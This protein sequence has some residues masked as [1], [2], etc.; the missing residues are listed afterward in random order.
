MNQD[1]SSPIPPLTKIEANKLGLRVARQIVEAAHDLDAT[2]EDT[3]IAISA[4]REPTP[5]WPPIDLLSEATDGPWPAPVRLHCQWPSGSVDLLLHVS[6][7]RTSADAYRHLVGLAVAVVLPKRRD[8]VWI[9]IPRVLLAPRNAVRTVRA[10]VTPPRKKGEAD[11][12]DLAAQRVRSVVKRAGL[13]FDTGANV[14]AF[15]VQLSDGT[16]LPS[17]K[18][19][20]QRICTLA[21]GKLPFF[22]TDGKGITGAPPFQPADVVVDDDD[23]APEDLT[24]SG[25]RA[26]IWPL[27]GGV[28]K[29]KVTLDTL[30]AELEAGSVPVETMYEILR[31][32]FDV[33]GETSREQYVNVIEAIGL[34]EKSDGQIGLTK[35]GRDYLVA[36]NASDV[37]DR[38]HAAFIGVLEP[39]VLADEVPPLG[40]K[41]MQQRMRALLGVEW[42]SPNQFNFRRNWLYSLGLTERRDDGDNLTQL[43]RDTVMRYTAEADLVRDRIG[44]VL[45]Q[46]GPDAG[47]DIGETKATS[48]NVPEVSPGLDAPTLASS[49]E[50]PAWNEEVVDL[51]AEHVAPFA[52][53]LVLPP[54]TIER[55]VAALSAGKHLL[56]V[57][58][59]G[60]AKTELAHFIAQAAKR[61]GY[62]AG[63]HVATASADWT[64][65]DT[66][67]G[68]ALQRDG[69]LRFREGAL[70]RAVKQWQWLIVD[71]LNRADV[72][73]AFGELMTVLA[74]RATDTS[75]ELDDGKIVK[76]GLAPDATH[77]TP[78]TFR[79]I[80]TMNT[81]D[82]T[83]LFRLSHA[84]QRR[85][86]IV[87]V[88][89]PADDAYGALVR[90]H[91]SL[92]GVA[93]APLPLA[94]ASSLATLFSRSGLLAARHI[95]PAVALDVIKY[96]RRR[97]TDTGVSAID[98]LAEA[99]AMYVLPQLEGIDQDRA[100]TCFAAIEILAT[101]CSPAARKELRE[102]FAD[103]FPHVKLP[104]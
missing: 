92:P 63:A 7:W 30:L 47:S 90:K 27:P 84:V 23:V 45:D 34:I 36:K 100:V 89:I 68:Y 25:K 93:D 22:V 46:V 17:A 1:G 99:I 40:G 82:K 78:R 53:D 66:I 26:G 72:D 4:K 59:P 60:T 9:T 29:Y 86:A 102:R 69:S 67:G 35:D 8:V 61:E 14:E 41:T 18:E 49:D 101:S 16:V 97:A 80:A 51:R 11:E 13:S 55:A 31:E 95:G 104:A 94:A 19:A 15:R 71:E 44:Q 65:F 85:F 48:A 32:Q 21:L 79:V 3:K 54:K 43:G 42:E 77:A 88:D 37:F 39:L 6:Y 58:P 75:F 70:L 2:I 38:L 64:T 24:P 96:A 81:W 87:H 83:S 52:K 5:S 74:G 28:S 57:G 73:R 56:L 103:L 20:Y 12:S 62:I 33:K 10:S 98:A 50:P 76:I 91:A